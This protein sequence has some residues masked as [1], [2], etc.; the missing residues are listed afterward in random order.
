MKILLLLCFLIPF[1]TA[2]AYNEKYIVSMSVNLIKMHEGFSHTVY[3]CPNGKRT[4][5]YGTTNFKLNVHFVTKKQAEQYLVRD[6]K[7][8]LKQI[9]RDNPFLRDEHYIALI[10]LGYNVGYYG[11]RR[12]YDKSPDTLFNR[13]KVYNKSNIHKAKY[14][15]GLLYDIMSYSYASFGGGKKVIHSGLLDRRFRSI[16]IWQNDKSTMQLVRNMDSKK[17]LSIKTSEKVKYRMKIMH[18]KKPLQP[19]YAKYNGG[20]LCDMLTWQSD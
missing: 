3:N 12:T 14:D 19:H 1:K 4:I 15:S 16:L 10:D 17:F 11:I 18:N 2:I 7:I 9:T 6:V 8:L 13:L 5:G 20:S